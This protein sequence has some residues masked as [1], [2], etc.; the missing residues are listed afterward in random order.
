MVYG[1]SYWSIENV[2]KSIV[3]MDVQLYEHFKNHSSF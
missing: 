2:L 1:V 3:M